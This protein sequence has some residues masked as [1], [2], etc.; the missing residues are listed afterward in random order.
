[1]VTAINQ[2]VLTKILFVAAIVLVCSI[3]LIQAKNK[4]ASSLILKQKPVD[5]VLGDGDLQCQAQTSERDVYR[6]AYIEYIDGI[7]GYSSPEKALGVFRSMMPN[8]PSEE[9]VKTQANTSVVRYEI[10]DKAIF[11]VHKNDAGLW[12]PYIRSVCPNIDWGKKI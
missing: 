9:I 11:I 7:G 6:T 4:Q 3:Y 12:Q 1:M 5:V 2:K 8:M 10:Q